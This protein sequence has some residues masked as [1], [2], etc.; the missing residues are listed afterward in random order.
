M[1]TLAL[2][3]TPKGGPWTAHTSQ[4]LLATC[5][6]PAQSLGP[7]W[8]FRLISGDPKSNL[9]NSIPNLGEYKQASSS[10]FRP[11][12]R[13][14][15]LAKPDPAPPQNYLRHHHHH[16]GPPASQ[17]SQAVQARQPY[18][19]PGLFLT[20]RTAP[21]PVRNSSVASGGAEPGSPVL[22]DW[23]LTAFFSSWGG[24]E[25]RTAVHCFKTNPPP[26]PGTR[27][28]PSCSVVMF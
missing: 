15:S 17:P 6:H 22:Q 14:N 9:P 10:G 13:Q 19:Q 28:R 2:C 21:F 7:V 24:K 3:S 4:R 23:L 12:S 1:P 5:Q 20:C 25:P 16:P 8:Y 27:L 26:S 18:M 11:C